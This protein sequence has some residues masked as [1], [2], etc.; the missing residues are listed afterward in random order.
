MMDMKNVSGLAISFA[1]AL[2]TSIMALS[3]PACAEDNLRKA[4]E[5]Q[6]S[7]STQGGLYGSEEEVYCLNYFGARLGHL[8]H[9]LMPSLCLACTLIC[10]D[11][12]LDYA[13]CR[14][15]CALACGLTGGEDSAMA[16]LGPSPLAQS[17]E[18]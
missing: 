14:E 15:R 9:S 12:N 5:I 2:F 16:R 8:A 3:M 11:E 13:R 4:A 18:P 6:S 17:R 1:F 10:D 7:C